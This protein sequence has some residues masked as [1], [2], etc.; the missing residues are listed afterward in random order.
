MSESIKYFEELAKLEDEIMERY[1]RLRERIEKLEKLKER[2]ENI[3][4]LIVSGGSD[5]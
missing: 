4:C 5:K 2:I 1:G 3:E